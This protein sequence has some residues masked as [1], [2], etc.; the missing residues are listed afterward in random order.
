M[1]DNRARIWFSLFVLAVFCLGGA[2]GFVADRLLSRPPGLGPGALDAGP[3]GRG[4]RPPFGIGRRGGAPGLFGLGRGG[5]PP[6]PPELMATLASELQLDA[7]QQDQVKK[8]LDEHRA[9]LYEVHREARA[10]F[11]QEQQDL[12]NAVRGVLRPDQQDKFQRFLERRR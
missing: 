10:K 4:M 12:Q 3:E 2:A 6:L 7:G 5:P 1:P 11:D 9:H 8:I